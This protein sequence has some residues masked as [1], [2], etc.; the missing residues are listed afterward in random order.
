MNIV[1]L[2]YL[3]PLLKAL[4]E[5]SLVHELVVGYESAYPQG[6]DIKKYCEERDIKYFC[7]DKIKNNICAAKLLAQAD[8]VVVAAFSQILSEKELGMPKNGFLN[9]HT[10]YLPYFKGGSPIEEAILQ[11][12]TKYGYTF[13]FLSKEIDSGDIVL[14]RLIN[15]NELPDYQTVLNKLIGHA[16]GD[17]SDLMMKP[18]NSWNRNIQYDSCKLFMPKKQEDAALFLGESPLLWQRKVKAFGW[19]GWAVLK[20]N[21]LRISIKSMVINA[22]SATDSN[23]TD[24]IIF[25]QNGTINFYYLD[26]MVTII[27]FDSNKSIKSG[28]NIFDN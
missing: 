17:L 4:E 15:F 23:K 10:S 21:S 8:I 19:R 16:C 13:H 5:S 6:L 9:F 11:G 2:G 12:E 1:F 22:V 27:D 18:F 26:Y 25:L 20:T 7:A 24:G 14:R 3:I 28:Q